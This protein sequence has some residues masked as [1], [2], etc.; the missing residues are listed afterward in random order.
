MPTLVELAKCKIQVYAGDHAPPRF[1]I[2]GPG[3]NAYVAIETLEIVAG[4]AARK[5]LREARAWA[6]PPSSRALLRAAWNRLN[7]RG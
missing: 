6:S 1:K 3:A 7:A 5:A 4:K 2:Y